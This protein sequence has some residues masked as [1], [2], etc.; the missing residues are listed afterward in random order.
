M[1]DFSDRTRT[2]ISILTSAAD[3]PVSLYWL[4]IF[5]PI[6]IVMT[7]EYHNYMGSDLSSEKMKYII[8]GFFCSVL[9]F[10]KIL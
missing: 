4:I 7:Y 5:D 6:Y 1:L 8:N 3:I 10:Q 9:T 2:G